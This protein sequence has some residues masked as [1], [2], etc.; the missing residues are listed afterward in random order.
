MFVLRSALQATLC[1]SQ[2]ILSSVSLNIVP[3]S[4]Q[5]LNSRLPILTRL[6]PYGTGYDPYSEYPTPSPFKPKQPNHFG[7]KKKF[8]DGGTNCYGSYQL[9]V[10]AVLQQ[11][12]IKIYRSNT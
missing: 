6:H 9:N 8:Y 11:G 1:K 5:C 3:N 4:L 7:Y 12:F 2:Q 10:V